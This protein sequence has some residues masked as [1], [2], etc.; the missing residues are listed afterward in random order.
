MKVKIKTPTALSDIKLSQYKKLVR[1]TD[2]SEDDSFIARQMVGIFCNISDELVGK[3]RAKDFDS[4]VESITKALNE[5][6]KFKPRFKLDG[7]EYGFIP[8][9]EE[10]TVGEKADLD[11]FYQ[12]VQKMDKAMSVLY[13]PITTKRGGSYLIED[14]TAKEL[15]LD[16]T[17]DIV[18]GANVFFSNLMSDLLNYTQNFIKAEVEHNPKA[19]QILEQNGDGTTAFI[20]SLELT[21]SNLKRLVNLN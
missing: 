1:T 9:L 15:P 20:N 14:Y 12:D 13:R 16:L 3:I 21:F 8:N 17:L 2:K 19:S 4:I 7:V 6:P 18:F 11:T 10:I 5:K